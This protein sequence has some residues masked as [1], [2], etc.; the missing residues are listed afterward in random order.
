[1]IG[2]MDETGAASG[3]PTLEEMR[4]VRD[5][6]V[7][8][9]LGIELVEADADHVVLRLPVGPKV[10][11]PYGFLHGGVS[12]VLAETGSSIGAWM[13]AGE[14]F[15]VF[16]IDINASHLRAVRDGIVTST[17]TPVRQ[18]RAIAVWNTEITDEQGRLVCVS[19]CTLAVKPAGVV[20]ERG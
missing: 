11:Q 9:A 6:T 8:G 17:S 1:M 12:V 5:T 13:R 16:G 7:L 14:G 4:G 19:R 2:G 10:H 15:E 20:G 3:I 18:G